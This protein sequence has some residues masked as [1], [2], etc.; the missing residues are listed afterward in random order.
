MNFR[1]SR[2]TFKTLSALF[3]VPLVR[4][5]AN[6]GTECRLRAAVKLVVPKERTVGKVTT[7]PFRADRREGLSLTERLNF[8]GAKTR[9]REL[10][11]GFSVTVL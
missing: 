10:R 9:G 8:A 1:T 11:A 2:V 7:A 6:F 5:S 4:P 3:D